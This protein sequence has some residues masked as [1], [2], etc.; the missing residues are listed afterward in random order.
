MIQSA[1]VFGAAAVAVLV[2]PLARANTLAGWSGEGSVSAGYTTGNTETSDF[3]LGVK[4]AKEVEKWRL[5]G[6]AQAEFG[7][8]AGVESKNRY[9]VAGTVDR[10]INDR[11]FGYGRSS[12]ESD[13]FS[14]YDSRGFVGGG[15]GY[16]VI[17]RGQTSWTVRGGPGAKIDEIKAQGA[18][19]ATSRTAF[20]VNLGSEFAHQFN[21]AVAFSNHATL[22]YAETSTQIQNIAALTA[23]LTE[24]LS[25]RFAVDVR[26]D[27]EP[28]GNF[29]STD[30]ATRFSF[31]YAF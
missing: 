29:E 10:Q 8:N 15:L 16:Q 27:T 31:V 13:Q 6:E 9:F 23:K 26:H 4:A 24:K 21:D 1:C 18:V 14:G 28:Q 11:L 17:I 3:A 12:Y 5:T 7:E 2:A 25:A 19:P 30:T 22:V 20:A